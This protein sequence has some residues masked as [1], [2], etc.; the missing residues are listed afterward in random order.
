[1]Q[2]DIGEV[3]GDLQ[4]RNVTGQIKDAVYSDKTPRDGPKKNTQL[5]RRLAAVYVYFDNDDSGYAPQNA[6]RL[7]ELVRVQPGPN[8]R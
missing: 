6:L 2:T 1:M 3:G 7:K 8:R 5:N 4:G